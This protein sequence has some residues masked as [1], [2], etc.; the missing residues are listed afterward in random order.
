[1]ALPAEA[2]ERDRSQP[3]RVTASLGVVGLTPDT[4]NLAELLAC[5]DRALYSAKQS[6]RN[7]IAV[8]E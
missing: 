1:L 2:D 4:Q 5:V 8:G 6:G 7:R 3:V